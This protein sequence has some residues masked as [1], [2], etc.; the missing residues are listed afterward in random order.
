[1]EK[2][3]NTAVVVARQRLLSGHCFFLELPP[4]GFGVLGLQLR[5]GVGL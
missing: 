1:M 2:R 3:M 4:E 5:L